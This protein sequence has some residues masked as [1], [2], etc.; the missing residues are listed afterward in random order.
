MT[1]RLHP[2]P[3]CVCDSVE[4][5]LCKH[6]FFCGNLPL[7]PRTEENTNTTA[8]PS[9]IS[10]V[11]AN[12][13]VNLCTWLVGKVGTEVDTLGLCCVVVFPACVNYE[14]PATR[15]PP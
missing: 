4:V 15:L 11:P 9:P 14:P 8:M 6:G 1:T 5:G 2:S 10:F 7:R 3:V 12:T 13:Y